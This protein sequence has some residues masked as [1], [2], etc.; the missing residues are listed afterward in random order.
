MGPVG[1]GGGGGG[2]GGGRWG[3]RRAGGGVSFNL[4]HRSAW[5]V[6]LNFRPARLVLFCGCGSGGEC[7]GAW[8][9]VPIVQAL[10]TDYKFVGDDT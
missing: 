5:L 9:L 3:G 10:P 8:N 2:L 4:V 6:D 1:G 7:G